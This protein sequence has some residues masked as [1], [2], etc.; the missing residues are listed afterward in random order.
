MPA[1]EATFYILLILAST[2]FDGAGN[3]PERKHT[4]GLLAWTYY[5]LQ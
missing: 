4:Q 1:T 5:I 2:A 3:A